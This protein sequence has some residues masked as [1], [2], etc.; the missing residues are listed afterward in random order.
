MNPDFDWIL[1][2]CIAKMRSGVS[3]E[4]C[5]AEY[6]AQAETLA[7]LLFAF[8]RAHS[9][10][11]ALA[12]PEVVQ[13]GREH[14]LEAFDAQFS[15][16]PVL[17]IPVSTGKV[18]R[19]IGRIFNTL[20]NLLIGK[21]NSGM[22]LALRLAFD[23]IVILIVGGVLVVNASAAS[24]PGDPLYGIKRS[25]EDV[26]LT[27]T[28]DPQAQQ[29]L[30]NQQ[31]QERLAEVESLVNQG[32]SAIVKF[33]AQITSIAPDVWIVGGFTLQIGPQTVID[34][35]PQPG[36]R[37]WVKAQVQNDGTLLGLQIRITSQPVEGTPYPGPGASSTPVPPMPSHTPQHT[38]EPSHTAET[39]HQPTYEATHTPWPT[40]EPTHMPSM[41]PWPTHEPTWE[42]T[43]EPTHMPEMTPWAT[44][45]PG[46][47]PMPTH[48]P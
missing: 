25:W 9:M 5:L 29:T 39:T 45:M 13:A 3:L 8:Q 42:P 6:P 7:P 38:P 46:M 12:R 18:S 48:H 31:L 15:S 30:Q 28:L 27:F 35:T 16:R 4:A 34:G 41:T 26:R 20:R 21:D 40:H 24:L 10:P 11:V 1:E 37:A 19:Y 47:T 2:E 33:E 14:V 23:L 43:H 32:R 44:H 22:K 17:A 36:E